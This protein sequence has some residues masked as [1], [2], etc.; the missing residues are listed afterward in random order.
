MVLGYIVALMSA[1]GYG[2]GAVIG[3]IIINDHAPPMVATAYSLLIGTVLLGIMSAPYVKT[4][5]KRATKRDWIMVTLAGLASTWGVSFFL[6]ALDNAPVVVVS[7]I[8]SIY[9]LLVIALSYLFLKQVERIT[10]QMVVGAA[11]VVG[12]VAS[13]TVGTAG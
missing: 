9:P 6:L 10:W 4:D 13:I 2:A 8:A 11:L 12:G 1:A 5:L 3:R 7:P